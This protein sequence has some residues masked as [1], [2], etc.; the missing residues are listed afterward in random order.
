W[1]LT[2]GNFGIDLADEDHR[3]A[4][5]HA[6]QRDD[7]ED[8]NESH[9]RS[10][11]KQSGGNTDDSQRCGGKYKEQPLKTLQL[12]HEDRD[13]DED[14]DRKDREDAGLSLGALLDRAAYNHVV[15]RR[16]P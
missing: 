16:S 9:R 2:R 15:A 3:I 7:P 5:H 13:H 14:H 12:D 6:D 1:V 4:D 10:R 11:D 8:R